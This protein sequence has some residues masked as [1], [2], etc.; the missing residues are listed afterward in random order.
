MASSHC[1]YSDSY[2]VFFR[3]EKLEDRLKTALLEAWD[4]IPM[5]ERELLEAKKCV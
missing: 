2:S 1:I 3:C 5:P 4:P